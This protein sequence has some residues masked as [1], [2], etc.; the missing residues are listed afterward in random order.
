MQF[1]EAVFEKVSEYVYPRSLV[2]FTVFV[3]SVDG[4]KPDD[5]VL[6]PEIG[7]LVV[8]LPATDAAALEVGLIVEAT[9]LDEAG[10]AEDDVT[11]VDDAC[12]LEEAVPEA[13]RSEYVY[14]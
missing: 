13:S 2:K 8:R 4:K 14:P 6:A 12:W 3:Q 7:A 11:P 5:M 9:L 1:V 10:L